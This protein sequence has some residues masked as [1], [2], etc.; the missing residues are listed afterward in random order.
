MVSSSLS[1]SPQFSRRDFL[2]RATQWSALLAAYQLLPLPALAESQAKDSRV[3]RTPIVDKGFASVR[4]VGE[5]L[6]ATISDP[7]KGLQTICNGG[8][9][10]GKDAALLLEGFVSPAGAGFQY[11]TLRT[12]SQGPIMGALDTHYHYDHTSGNSFYGA[13][14]ISLWGHA[15]VSK[16]IFDSYGVMQGVDK[17]AF[18][19]PLE[20]RA[21]NAKTEAARKHASELVTTMGNIFVVANSSVLAFP[22]RPLDPAKLPVKLDLGG[23]T[24]LVETHPGH[25]GTDL[26]VR[27]P[28]QNVVYTGDLLFNNLYPVTFDEQAT[29]SGWRSTLKTFL[30]YDKDTIFIPGHGQVGGRDAVQLSADLFD[31]VAAQAEK[32]YKSGVPAEDAAD[33]YVVP[34]KY[35][36]VTIFAWNLSIGPTIL[37]LYKEWSAK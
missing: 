35:K 14:G 4:K 10:I 2:G 17:A 21:K 19:A 6:Y 11:E 5:G 30:S 25:S 9:L 1:A 20:A 3:A 7:S 16:R 32:M 36:D 24:A 15:G 23:L 12:L 26:I 8:I 37:K 27:V 33:Q 34:D 29:V 28:E 22:N 31:D 18:L 13:N